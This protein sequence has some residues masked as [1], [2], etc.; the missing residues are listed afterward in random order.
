MKRIILVKMLLIEDS[1]I[2]RKAIK[3]GLR[4]YNFEF[5]EAE[6]GAA[7]LKLAEQ[8]MPDIILLDL[9]LPDTSGFE[10][11][12]NIRQNRKTSGIPV[13]ITTT[14]NST[15]DVEKAM[16]SGAVYY[17]VKPVHTGKL[18]AKV[19]NLLKVT[20]VEISS[21][22]FEKKEETGE[23]GEDRVIKKTVSYQKI[24]SGNLKPGMIIGIP[25]T[26]SDGKILYKSNVVL[27]GGK[28]EAIIQNNIGFV[29]IK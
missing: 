6:D 26:L 12:K 24:E 15:A 18:L 11:L 22:S 27:D 10:V 8:D 28:I 4:N 3:E 9:N 1:T 25:V 29:Y 19:M 14:S 21:L 5:V 17:F 7:G 2:A 23:D 13:I 20:E 16:Q